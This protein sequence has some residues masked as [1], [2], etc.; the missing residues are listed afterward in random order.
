MHGQTQD[1]FEW[2]FGWTLKFGLYSFDPRFPNDYV[3]RK[4]AKVLTCM[5]TFVTI[6]VMTQDIVSIFKQLPTKLQ[7]AMWANGRLRDTD[8]VA[9]LNR[10]QPVAY[11]WKG[12]ISLQPRIVD[13]ALAKADVAETSSKTIQA[14]GW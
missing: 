14:V 6:F 2:N 13:E 3:L 1:N 9:Y 7:S 5:S 10:L 11:D 8:L 12:I 4:G